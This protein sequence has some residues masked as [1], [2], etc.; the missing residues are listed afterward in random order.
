V[1]KFKKKGRPVGSKNKKKVIKVKTPEPKTPE[2]VDSSDEASEAESVASDV[3]VSSSVSQQSE[4]KSDESAQQVA[5]DESEGELV[6]NET[7]PT[8]Y[9]ASE[10]FKCL[11]KL[12]ATYEELAKYHEFQK[13]GA[14]TKLDQRGLDLL[15]A[16]ATDKP[17]EGRT[18]RCSF[19]FKIKITKQMLKTI[20]HN[21]TPTSTKSK[22][23]T[24][25]AI[26]T[27]MNQYFY[28]KINCLSAMEQCGQTE[29]IYSKKNGEE[30]KVI[31]TVIKVSDEFFEEEFCDGYL[32]YGAGR[33]ILDAQQNIHEQT[34]S[35]K[36]KTKN[37]QTKAQEAKSFLDD[38][39]D[40]ARNEFLAKYMNK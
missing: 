23:Y 16:E 36:R 31:S 4:A 3:S 18:D 29:N 9:S 28:D 30:D 11:A 33:K 35:I 7:E 27:A 40:E 37:K 10:G 38:M 15:E 24:D 22:Q 25:T 1:T 26:K 21:L 2:L 8:P 34:L 5:T 6:L 20:Q 39:T 12:G 13:V 19:Q 17:K 32:H 14:Y